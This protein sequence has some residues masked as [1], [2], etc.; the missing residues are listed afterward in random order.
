M[1]L[2]AKIFLSMS[3]VIALS[4]AASLFSVKTIS[5]MRK[6]SDRLRECQQKVI[7]N[8]EAA[9]RNIHTARTDLLLALVTSD[10]QAMNRA[11]AVMKEAIRN[12]EAIE[13]EQELV[14]KDMLAKL[15]KSRAE[16]ESLRKA[17]S[18]AFSGFQKVNLNQEQ[19]RTIKR[20]TQQGDSLSRSLRLMREELSKRLDASFIDQQRQGNTASTITIAIMLFNLVIGLV[21]AMIL[22]KRIS[23]ATGKLVGGLKT[24]AQ[25]QGD[26]TTRFR[27]ESQDELGEAVG[28]F[29][30]FMDTLSD[31]I[32][33]VKDAVGVVQ[34]SVAQTSSAVEELSATVEETAQT[35]ASIAAAAEELE[36]TAQ[37][38]ERT[39]ENVAEKAENNQKVASE[40][41]DYVTRLTNHIYNIKNDFE[42]IASSINKLRDGAEAIKE[43]ISVINDI[44]DQTNLLALN[45]AIEAARAGEHGRGFAVVADEVR[46]LAE[47]TTAQT[48]SIE[49]IISR[50]SGDIEEYVG[51]VEENTK[52]ME[53]VHEFAEETMKVLE[54]VKYESIEAM[55]NMNMI[56]NAIKEQQI[57]TTQVSQGLHEINIAVDEAS[58]ALS[59]ISVSIREIVKKVEELKNITDGFTV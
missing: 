46:K 17:L 39:A 40:G 24:L 58:K 47:K 19:M 44:A 10:R 8:I 27:V 31:M 2:K 20:L 4:L 3:V 25:G 21:L 41:Y 16:I 1:S 59:D 33:K 28:R 36:K 12:L 56:K 14:T 48:R 32:R 6:T 54:K 55:E 5:S 18:K 49:E 38:L 9:D 50:I 34:D 57:A 23:T 7:R 45:A 26:L 22:S 43:V 11:D 30:R 37:E 53:K 29:N 15:K 51:A 13:K 35:T 52:K 42:R